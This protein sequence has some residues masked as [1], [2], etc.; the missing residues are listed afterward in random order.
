MRHCGVFCKG[1]FLRVAGMAYG[2]V[3]ECLCQMAANQLVRRSRVCECMGR[4]SC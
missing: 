2:Q 3:G 4:P 1:F